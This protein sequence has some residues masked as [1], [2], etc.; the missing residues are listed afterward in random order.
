MEGIWENVVSIWAQ[1]NKM[2]HYIHSIA[3]D[4]Y[5]YIY[6]NTLDYKSF[7]CSLVL[8]SI[9]FYAFL[10]NSTPKLISNYYF[11]LV[12]I[13][14]SVG[15]LKEKKNII[16][17]SLIYINFTRYIKEQLKCEMRKMKCE[18]LTQWKRLWCWVGL[19]AGRKGENVTKVSFEILTVHGMLVTAGW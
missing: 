18:E 10:A 6:V 8:A 13:A 7:K 14:F 5:I 1:E 2:M 3:S 11:E 16:M 12:W 19:G 9:F 17:I 4:I 15:K